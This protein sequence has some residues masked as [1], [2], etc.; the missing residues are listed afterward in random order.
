MA[1]F[2]K[3]VN[4]NA[5]FSSGDVKTLSVQTGNYSNVIQ[6]MTSNDE[7]LT[8]KFSNKGDLKEALNRIIS[9]ALAIDWDKDYANEYRYMFEPSEVTVDTINEWKRDSASLNSVIEG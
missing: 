3:S 8:V 2:S 1:D 6:L 5:N 9:A 7:T 4:V